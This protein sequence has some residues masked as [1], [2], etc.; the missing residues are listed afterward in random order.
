MYIY[1]TG[2]CWRTILALLF[3]SIGL[4][5]NAIIL[6]ITNERVPRDQIPLRDLGFELSSS[7][8]S[9]VPISISDYII[10]GQSIGII[11]LLFAHKYRYEN[12]FNSK[13]MN[14]VLN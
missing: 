2:S 12:E 8:Q 13:L 3:A 14:S 9:Y 1:S 5:L 6:V 11:L 10:I 7:A 4:I